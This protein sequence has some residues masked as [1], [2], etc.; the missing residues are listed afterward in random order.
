MPRRS[1]LFKGTCNPNHPR[2]LPATTMCLAWTAPHKICGCNRERARRSHIC[3]E[4]DP[5]IGRY[6]M[7]SQSNLQPCE[8]CR[9][10]RDRRVNNPVAKCLYRLAE[11]ERERQ[12]RKAERYFVKEALRRCEYFRS[13]PAQMNPRDS[14]R[15]TQAEEVQERK[16]TQKG[17]ASRPPKTKPARHK[18][19]N[20]KKA[21]RATKPKKPKQPNGL[22]RKWK[23]DQTETN[24]Y[25]KP[26]VPQKIQHRLRC[27]GTVLRGAAT[28]V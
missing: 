6:L 18:K 17:Q 19:R 21:K 5:C 1:H 10:K 27:N 26:P 28:D 8:E 15:D 3:T 12:K 24:P 4:D 2:P 7:I 20:M 25:T 14:L 16:R 22:K 9:E 23:Q 11:D 13:T